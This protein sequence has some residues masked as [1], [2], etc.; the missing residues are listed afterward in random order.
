MESIGFLAQTTRTGAAFTELVGHELRDNQKKLVCSVNQAL[1]TLG[2]NGYVPRRVRMVVLA[3]LALLGVFDDHKDLV[4]LCSESTHTSKKKHLSRE[5]RET[6][7]KLLKQYK[8]NLDLSDTDAL[9]I[10]KQLEKLALGPTLNPPLYDKNGALNAIY[11]TILRGAGAHSI[12]LVSGE[13][14]ILA[15]TAET[16]TVFFSKPA[17]FTRP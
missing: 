13:R 15:R 10:G 12:L 16:K 5:F 2:G 11:Q 3:T 8:A 7:I 17:T 9:A 14:P 4:E 1:E 6:G